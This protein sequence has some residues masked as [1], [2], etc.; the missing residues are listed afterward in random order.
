MPQSV[1]DR[2]PSFRRFGDPRNP[3]HILPRRVITRGV[4][5]ETTIELHPPRL[6]VFRLT[7][8]EHT[9]QTSGLSDLWLESSS[10]TT[11]K[12]LLRDLAVT[13]DSNPTDEYRVWK[14][15]GS[16]LSGSDYPMGKLQHE[17][18][19]RLQLSENTLSDELI[20]SGDAFV[21]EF[22]RDGKWLADERAVERRS[23]VGGG[24]LALVLQDQVPQP[25]FSQD[26]DFFSR[27]GK[28]PSS[29]SNVVGPSVS[30]TG[31]PSSST[32]LKPAALITLSS[33]LRSKPAYDPGTLGLGNM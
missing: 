7:S 28:S 9:L 18:S 19:E 27:L 22:S 5:R 6:R 21:V 17:G 16:A 33:N 29:T 12:D 24:E 32:L 2:C 4:V 10:A 8:S 14:V 30:A 1:F 25:L 23:A 3:Q 11:V 26:T 20:E 15:E 31:A 13:A